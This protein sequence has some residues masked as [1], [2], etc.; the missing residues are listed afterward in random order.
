MDG[1]APEALPHSRVEIDNFESTTKVLEDW[2]QTEWPSSAVIPQLHIELLQGV[3]EYSS[4]GLIPHEPGDP[5]REDI[6]VTGEPENFF[7]RGTDVAPVLRSYF[8][9][10]DERLA[11]LPTNPQDNVAEIVKTAAWSYYVFERIH[12]F[13]DCNGRTGRLILTRVMQGANLDPIIFL[14]NWFDQE[15]ENHLDAMNLADE[16]GDLTALE[17]YLLNAIKT[18]HN[19]KPLEKEI[20]SLI[21]E[22]GDTLLSPRQIKSIENIWGKFGE[23]DIASPAEVL[24]KTAHYQAA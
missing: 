7:V 3:D 24:Q 9:E 16:T 15:R 5:R 8:E 10:L 13:F 19:N 6:K 4:K 1:P 17:L 12:P 21:K 2:V 22:K 23:I 14:D 18:N 11:S 20:D